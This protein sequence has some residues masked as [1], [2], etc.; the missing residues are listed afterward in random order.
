MGKTK[1][2]TKVSE[3]ALEELRSYARE[4]NRP[5]SDVVDE[6]IKAHLRMVRVRPVFRSAVD[7]VIEQHAQALKRPAK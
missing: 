5:I 2:A 6:A 3:E 1:F 4:S 7:Q